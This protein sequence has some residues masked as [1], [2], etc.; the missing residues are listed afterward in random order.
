MNDIRKFLR[1]AKPESYFNF[2]DFVI[3]YLIVIPMSAY[4]EHLD[5]L[6]WIFLSFSALLYSGIYIINDLIDLPR[7]R[8]HPVKRHRPIASKSIKPA[9]ALVIAIVLMVAGLVT[10]YLIN[11]TVF[12]FEI[13]FVFVNLL[14]SLVLNRIAYLD[15][16]GCTITHPLRTVFAIC[17]YGQLQP[18]HWPILTGITIIWLGYNILKR[19]Q[20]LVD[21]GDSVRLSLK[22]HSTRILVY[23]GIGCCPILIALFFLANS[24]LY[25]ILIAIGNVYYIS[26]LVAYLRGGKKIKKAIDYMLAN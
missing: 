1:L 2:T 20:E 24:L 8:Q 18:S 7:D 16:I 11:P 15:L 5:S 14:Y 19:H 6:L 21:V 12:F 17:A 13:A 10:G 23:S 26:L 22:K 3:G 25:L 4:Q 9:V